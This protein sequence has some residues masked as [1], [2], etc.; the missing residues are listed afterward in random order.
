MILFG[1]KGEKRMR[2]IDDD[3][4]IN[5]LE[6]YGKYRGILAPTGDGEWDN[7]IPVSMAK[8][9]V[10]GSDIDDERYGDAK[11]SNIIETIYKDEKSV[12]VFDIDGVL[13]KYEY[14]DHNHNICSDE[15]WDSNAEYYSKLMYEQAQPVKLFQHLIN[16]IRA[17]KNVYACSVASADESKAKKKFVLRNYSIPEENIILVQ[18][19][20]D[21]LQALNNIKEQYPGLPDSKIILIDDTVKV[22]THVQDNSDYSTCHIS[23]FL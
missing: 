2:M 13:A 23:S 11:M 3:E 18:N 6:D 7:F 4:V 17:G 15:E 22:L 16:D 20:M 12:L 8:K 9:I 1:A 14:G 19:K 21:K 10:K 5:I